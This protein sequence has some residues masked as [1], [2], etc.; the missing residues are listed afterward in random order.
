MKEKTKQ[1][2][3]K[4]TEDEAEKIKAVARSYG[5][6]MR[7]FIVY[8]STQLEKDTSRA[9]IETIEKQRRTNCAIITEKMNEMEKRL[10]KKMDCFSELM[11]IAIKNGVIDVNEKDES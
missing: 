2:C 6:S 10:L 7:D 9:S 11:N 1:I 5:K 3:I 4:V 8:A